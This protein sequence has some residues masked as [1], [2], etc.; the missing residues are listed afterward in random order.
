MTV[1]VEQWVEDGR[2]LYHV[3]GM[4][5]GGS[6]LTKKLV[7]RFKAEEVGEPVTQY[8][9]STNATWTLWTHPWRPR[10]PGEY[11]IGLRIDDP[12]VRTRRLDNGH[13]LRRIRIEEV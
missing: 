11:S 13:Y 4:L 7:I 8:V 9:H 6:S 2:I 12:A 3:V 5:W 1:R 10:A